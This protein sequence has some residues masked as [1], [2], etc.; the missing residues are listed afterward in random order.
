M[1]DSTGHRYALRS[2]TPTLSTPNSSS[3]S[4]PHFSVPKPRLGESTPDAV[5]EKH[6]R[7]S[8]YGFGE[9]DS[10]IRFSP[11]GHSP[12]EKRSSSPAEEPPAKRRLEGMYDLPI[13]PARTRRP[14]GKAKRKNVQVLL[15]HPNFVH[16]LM[17]LFCAICSMTRLRW[18]HL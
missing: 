18:M 10:P 14:K 6:H 11:I 8:L 15:L 4:S 2:I 3:H 13:R 16:C 7:D 5:K 1:S 17:V 12:Y 9:L